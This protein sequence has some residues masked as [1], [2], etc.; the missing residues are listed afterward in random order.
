MI[1][2]ESLTWHGPCIIVI[3]VESLIWHTGIPIN[4]PTVPVPVELNTSVP[5][6]KYDVPFTEPLGTALQGCRVASRLLVN[7]LGVNQKTAAFI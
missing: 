6:P 3:L 5:L 7:I 1:L 2:A 4:R